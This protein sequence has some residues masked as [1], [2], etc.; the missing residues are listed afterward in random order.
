MPAPLCDM[1]IIEA[2]VDP[3]ASTGVHS[4]R[5]DE[6]HVILSGR[7]RFTQGDTFRARTGRDHCW[8]PTVPHVVENV[9]D[10]PGRILVIYPRAGRRGGSTADDAG[11]SG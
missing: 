4:H 7:W 9:G 11:R 8:D 5:G 3:G 2:V 1:C 6:H 10:E